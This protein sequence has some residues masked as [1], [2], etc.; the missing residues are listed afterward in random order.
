MSLQSAA[1]AIS[2]VSNV[3][4]ANYIAMQGRAGESVYAARIGVVGT[5]SSDESSQIT[6]ASWRSSASSSVSQAP[7]LYSTGSL[8][9]HAIP[10]NHAMPR[11]RCNRNMRFFCFHEDNHSCDDTRCANPR[12][13]ARAY[14]WHCADCSL[15][16]CTTCFPISF[17]PDDSFIDTQSS[18]EA[19]DTPPSDAAPRSQEGDDAAASGRGRYA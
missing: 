10:S 3:D 16:L 9:S 13:P 19:L 17:T 15:D 5:C 6:P 8:H 1:S 18:I 11:C 4:L 2:N 7:S 14:G 12:I